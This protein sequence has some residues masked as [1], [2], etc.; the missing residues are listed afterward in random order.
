MTEV[1]GHARRRCLI[2][3]IDQ[4]NELDVGP[5]VFASGFDVFL[6]ERTCPDNLVEVLQKPLRTASFN[7]RRSG[8]RSRSSTA[9]SAAN[10]PAE[11]ASGRL[12]TGVRRAFAETVHADDRFKEEPISQF[13]SRRTL[14][15]HRSV[16]SKA[17]LISVSS[18]AHPDE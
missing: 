1:T 12:Q 8:S 17:I 3:P 9:L 6:A 10:R 16:C 5:H 18:S 11:I 15:T 13:P 4:V 14:N 7:N 2:D